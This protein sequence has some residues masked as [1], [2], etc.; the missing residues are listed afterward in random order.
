MDENEDFQIKGAANTFNIIIEENVPNLKK[1]MPMN[2]KEAYRTP[3]RLDQERNSSQ[4]IIVRT[5]H[6]LI[7]YRTL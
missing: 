5:T 4:H 2:I 7:K 6:S 1:E 3:N